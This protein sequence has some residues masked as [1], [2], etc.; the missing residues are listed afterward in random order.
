MGAKETALIIH[1]IK[2]LCRNTDIS[3]IVIDH[4]YAHLFDI[5]D[6]IN[7]IQ[8]GRVTLDKDLSEISMEELIELMVQS[9][10]RELSRFMPE[11][12]VPT[13]RGGPE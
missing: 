3:V 9:H 13:T 6:R 4:N 8:Q 1:V 12:Q 10:R 11:S 2:G 5:C 7:V